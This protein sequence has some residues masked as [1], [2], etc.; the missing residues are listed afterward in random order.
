MNSKSR[1]HNCGRL[2]FAVIDSGLYSPGI[3]ELLRNLKPPA[4]G[5]GMKELNRYQELIA[6]RRRYALRR[7]GARPNP[8]GTIRSSVR[9]Q[10]EGSGVR[11]GPGS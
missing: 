4:V 5:T 8:D 11:C 3:P 10:P 6:E 9:Q 1:P 2:S 7:L